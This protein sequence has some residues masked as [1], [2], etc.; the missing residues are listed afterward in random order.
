MEKKLNKII[1][2]NSNIDIHKTAFNQTR[3]ETRISKTSFHN[4]TLF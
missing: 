2:H 3:E 1:F 4:D